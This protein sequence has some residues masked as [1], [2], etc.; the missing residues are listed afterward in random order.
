MNDQ[1]TLQPAELSDTELIDRILAG[2]KQFFEWIMRRYNQR[3]F[4]VG[5]SILGSDAE[6]EDAMQNAYIK[7][8]QHLNKFEQRASLSTWL[9]KILM[10]ECLAQRNK[11]ARLKLTN[12]EYHPENMGSMKTPSNILMNKELG[13]M[14]EAAIAELPEKY[15]LVFML[16]EIEELSVKETG[17]ILGIEEPNVKVRLNRAK[18]M[19]RQTLSSGVKE[20]VYAFHLTRCDR[21]VNHV[22]NSIA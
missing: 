11:K 3:L 13:I 4:R 6:V 16:R 17:D 22:L 9:V 1:A 19:L 20:H 18:A 10:N 5:I 2:E 14:L 7:A 12:I 15:R 21:L 8:Y